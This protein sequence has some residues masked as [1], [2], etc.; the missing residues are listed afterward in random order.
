MKGATTANPAAVQRTDYFTAACFEHDRGIPLRAAAVRGPRFQPA[1]T[2]MTFR[3]GGPAFARRNGSGANCADS[4]CSTDAATAR[5]ASGCGLV[6]WENGHVALRRLTFEVRGRRRC[7]ARP[8]PQ[9]MY[10]VPVAGA[11][12]HAVGAPLD[13]GVRPRFWRR[14]NRAKLV[15]KA[16]RLVRDFAA[17]MKRCLLLDQHDV[18]LLVCDW[19]V[20]HA[21]RH[22]KGLTFA[23]LNGA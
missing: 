14:S 22:D 5:T 6:R 8:R 9:K 17:S 1:M 4:A 18:A 11:W 21:F 3:H 16:T 19:V 23:Q 20:T 10:S 12:W 2:I 7:D 15:L 13:R